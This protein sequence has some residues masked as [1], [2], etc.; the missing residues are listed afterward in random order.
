MCVEFIVWGQKRGS[1]SSKLLWAYVCTHIG[2]SCIHI[3]I[4]YICEYIRAW[5][6]YYNV[7]TDNYMT[8]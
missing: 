3:Y 8:S 5:K 7:M 2:T 1:F 4:Y 6:R